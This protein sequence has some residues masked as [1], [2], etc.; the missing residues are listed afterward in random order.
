MDIFL[1]ESGSFVIPGN[2]RSRVS[3]VAAL[4]I[5]STRRDEILDRFKRIRTSW[6]SAAGEIK[7]SSLGETRISQVIQFLMEYRLIV[8][9][10]CTDMSHYS[11][12]HISKFKY[13]QA[14][15]MIRNLTEAHQ[16]SMVAECN[17]LKAEIEKLPNQLFVQMFLT[18][19]LLARV[20]QKGTLYF[21]QRIPEELS[22]FNWVVDAKGSSDKA[23]AYEKLWTTLMMPILQDNYSM[24]AL[25]GADYSHYARFDR[26]EK[27]LTDFQ[28]SRLAHRGPNIKVSDLDKIMNE[29]FAFSSSQDSDGV[30]LVD[31]LAS[32]FTRAMNGNLKPKGWRSL[33]RLTVQVPSMGF[34][35]GA[36]GA[37][38]PQ[39]STR[40]KEVLKRIGSR[41]KLMIK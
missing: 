11:D 28:R 1:D 26:D 34:L 2:G 33:G 15:N 7:G 10:C 9:F 3:C 5:P 38:L 18:L 29:S 32:A 12:E 40:H 6:G 21:V 35:D 16:P 13:V 24:D 22:S 39:M 25:E 17:R 23:T 8:D 20:L 4:I 36:G 41:R 31:I 30:Q 27:E 37:S 19:D 14:H